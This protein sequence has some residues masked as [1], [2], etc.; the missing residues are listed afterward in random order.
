MRN[1]PVLLVS[2]VMLCIGTMTYAQNRLMGAIA[3]SAPV[4]ILPEP[5]RTPLATL[6]EGTQVEVLS[7]EEQGWYRI[8]FHDRYLGDRVGYVRVENLK[9]SAPIA[10]AVAAVA[11]LDAAA[12]SAVT[13]PVETRNGSPSV[14]TAP[15]ETAKLER[16]VTPP[17]TVTANDPARA[18]RSSF[19]GLS[20]DSIATAISLGN[21]Q[22]GRTQGLRLLDSG[23]SFM[24]AMTAGG[25]GPTASNG[26]RL[27]VH[28]PLAWIRQLASDAAKEYRRF[29][30][31]DVTDQMTE[32]VLHVT[33]YPDTP[34]TV[35]AGGL[36]GTSS[37]QH[38][39][40]RSESR[41]LVVQPLAREAFSEEVSNAMGGKATYAGL[42]LTFAMD[43][44]RELRGPRGDREF[45]ITVI[46]SSNEEKNFK[47]KKKHFDDLPM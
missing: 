18:G 34:N 37:V 47:V 8:S 29:S 32:P 3:G 33:A 35:A 28:T 40:L 20:E 12:Q 6:R 24:A 22:K 44:V 39:V 14:S 42:H 15:R 16:A 45:F 2:A 11:P 25:T 23:Q 27:Q 9:L 19:N 10:S 30:L 17:G 7:D 41:D 5:G 26:F 1:W 13:A 4:V 43:A 31:D 38:V 21:R 46:G 36:Q